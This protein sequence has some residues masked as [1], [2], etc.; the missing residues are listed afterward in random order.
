[1]QL[2]RQKGLL[3]VFRLYICKGLDILKIGLLLSPAQR[4]Q[5]GARLGVKVDITIKASISLISPE[6]PGTTG[7]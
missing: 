6:A 4:P 3:S 2:L 5:G 1:M 7:Y